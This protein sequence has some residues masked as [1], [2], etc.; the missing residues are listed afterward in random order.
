MDIEVHHESKKVITQA[1][2]KRCINNE[3]AILESF[4]VEQIVGVFKEIK[5]EDNLPPLVSNKVH[6]E[7]GLVHIIETTKEVLPFDILIHLVTNLNRFDVKKRI[8]YERDF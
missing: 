3:E 5:K 6:M 1:E 2:V 4:V 7:K 8:N